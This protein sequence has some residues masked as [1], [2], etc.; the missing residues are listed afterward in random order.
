MTGEEF[1]QIA[2]RFHEMNE[3]IRDVERRFEMHV[4]STAEG[5]R[6]LYDKIDSLAGDMAEKLGPILAHQNKTLG[7]VGTIS[8]I[9]GAILAKLA[10]AFA[11]HR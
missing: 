1:R 10:D 4:A 9:G 6:R 11:F 3:R 8:I 2:E 7:I 5:E